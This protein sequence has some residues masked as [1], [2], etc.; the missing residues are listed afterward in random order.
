MKYYTEL[1]KQFLQKKNERKKIVRSIILPFL[2]GLFL[3]YDKG[4][5]K[6]TI[7]NIPLRIYKRSCNRKSNLN[8]SPFF[9]FVAFS[10]QL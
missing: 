8:K 7:K 9:Y 4:R 2:L 6:K 5:N 10:A 3:C 1:F